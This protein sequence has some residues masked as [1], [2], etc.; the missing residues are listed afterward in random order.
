MNSPVIRTGILII[1][2][3]AAIILYA[4]LF[5][6]YQTQQAV[7]LRFGAVRQV[8]TDPGLYI[9]APFIDVVLPVEKRVLD[10]DIPAQTV[11]SSD[12]QNLEV[13]AFARYRINDALRFYQ[14]VNNVQ[15]ANARLQ[16]FVNAAMR[17]TL[18]NASFP[19]IIRTS[20]VELMQRIAETVNRQASDLGMEV[21][22]VRL[23]R[24]D[25]PPANS[26][27]VFRRMQTERQREA[28][29]LR[30]QGAQRAQAIRA[31]ADRDVVVILAEATRTSE[32]LRGAGDADR[33]RIL[34]DAYGRDQDFFAFYRSMQAYEL[35][36][37][38][39]PEADTRLVLSPDSDFFRY[40]GSAAG[41]AVTQR[42][43]PAQAPAAPAGPMSG[44][45]APEA[46]VAPEA[47]ADAIPAPAQAPAAAAAAAQ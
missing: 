43:V 27:A 20:R 15:N 30:A 31:R 16:S 45:Q 39:T 26:E 5:T 14:A 46:P 10:L 44:L 2:G 24:V 23:T 1:L 9:K 41:R 7:V 25:L 8:I 4:S 19:E 36:L 42:D 34:A 21:I 22:D 17:N 12:R 47:P 37:R 28:A 3:L 18:A 35:A 6:V 29:D 33:N 32:E 40:F 38:S 13:D 11:L